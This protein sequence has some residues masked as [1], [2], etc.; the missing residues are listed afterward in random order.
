[1]INA[2]RDNPIPTLIVVIAG[3][4]GAVIL[5]IAAIRGEPDAGGLTF[6]T[7]LQTMIAG[8]V[9]LGAVRVADQALNKKDRGPD[10]V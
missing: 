3:V 9:G 5:M 6:Q 2:L 8:A 10:K 7:Y 4:A 1:M